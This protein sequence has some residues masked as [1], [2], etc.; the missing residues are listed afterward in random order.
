MI[1]KVILHWAAKN[2]ETPWA[3]TSATLWVTCKKHQLNDKAAALVK[4]YAADSVQY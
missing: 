1:H 3:K 2:P 4:L